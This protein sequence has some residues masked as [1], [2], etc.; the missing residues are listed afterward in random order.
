MC[1][2][3]QKNID[4]CIAAHSNSLVQICGIFLPDFPV[5]NFRKLPISIFNGD[6]VM[7]TIVRLLSNCT[8]ILPFKIFSNNSSNVRS[9]SSSIE[10]FGFANGSTNLSQ[11][12]VDSIDNNIIINQSNYFSLFD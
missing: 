3:T 5:N 2:W 4:I 1:S 11:I 6:D 7:A 12:N 10:M 9:A 8:S